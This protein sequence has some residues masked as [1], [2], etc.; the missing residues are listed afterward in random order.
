MP[1][2]VIPVGFT[3][4]ACNAYSGSLLAT[5]RAMSRIDPK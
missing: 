1:G 2:A 5:N 3:C 4:T